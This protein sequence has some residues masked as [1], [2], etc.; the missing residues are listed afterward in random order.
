MVTDHGIGIDVVQLRRVRHVMDL[1]ANEYEPM[2]LAHSFDQGMNLRVQSSAR[3]TERL[4][5]S[6]LV[7]ALPGSRSRSATRNPQ[8]SD[9]QGG[10]VMES[11][12]A[13]A[14]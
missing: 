7:S 4:R 9:A 2:W 12:P 14:P 6:F 13:A 5:A 3:S 10:V 1:A 8:S 11:A